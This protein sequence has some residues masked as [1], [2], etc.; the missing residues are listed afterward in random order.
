MKK[1]VFLTFALFIKIVFSKE[2]KI[3]FFDNSENGTKIGQLCSLAEKN[4]NG[5][6]Q[7]ISDCSEYFEISPIIKICGSKNGDQIICCPIETASQINGP[8][9]FTGFKQFED[10]CTV[11]K[12]NEK[13]FLKLIE[14][15]PRIKSE[16]KA[17]APFPRV[18]NYEV[19]RDMV[20]CPIDDK[21]HKKFDVCNEYDNA[22]YKL[23]N[24][25]VQQNQCR[26]NGE[27]GIYTDLDDCD[28]A[29]EMIKNGKNITNV[30]EYSFCEDTVCCP[31]P[32]KTPIR[33][34]AFVDSN[35]YFTK[36]VAGSCV[37]EITGEKGT[38]MPIGRCNPKYYIEN[39]RNY[40][41]CGHDYCN[42]FICCPTP[43]SKKKSLQGCARYSEAVFETTRNIKNLKS[44]PYKNYPCY[45][46]A[47]AGGNR[48]HPKEFPHMAAL[49]YQLNNDPI[50]WSCGGSLISDRFILTAGHCLVSRELGPVRYVKLG[51]LNLIHEENVGCPEDFNVIDRIAHPDYKTS[52]Y[53]N[54][55]ALLKLDR[56]VNFN[57]HIR[58]A[59]LPSTPEVPKKTRLAAMGWGQ[60]GA[61]DPT[62]DWLIHVSLTEFSYKECNES[63]K[64]ISKR[65]L[66]SG[67]NILTQ[68]CAGSKTSID[69]TCPVS[70]FVSCFF[71]L[72]IFF[73]FRVI[74]EVLFK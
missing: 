41:T 45:A 47:P 8:E 65:R 32:K 17:G 24:R 62:T 1:L 69:D 70:F 61:L 12:T 42:K 10:K 40:T 21:K 64:D 37:D 38:C 60:T 29:K 25:L 6:C 28:S 19:C 36:I 27:K 13:G 46:V 31:I 48:A 43:N 3:T 16:V 57:P 67:I 33:R 72:L 22:N 50:S 49:G 39:T 11:A 15:C 44:K 68:I 55:I 34:R 4:V 73:L 66:A 51:S 2:D 26:L 74:Q 54:D 30:C 7:L 71:L 23:I 35:F 63:F 52:S 53:Y 20:C 56:K 58:P 5:T 59:C 9:T 18:C 14:H